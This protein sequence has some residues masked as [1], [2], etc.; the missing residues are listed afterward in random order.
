MIDDWEEFVG[1]FIYVVLYLVI[2]GGGWWT[3]RHWGFFAW[4]WGCAPR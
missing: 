4:Y 3:L 2:V 1:A